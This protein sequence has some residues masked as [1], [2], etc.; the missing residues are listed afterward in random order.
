M[1]PLTLQFGGL[2]FGGGHTPTS[3]PGGSGS[4]NLPNVLGSLVS[5]QSSPSRGLGTIGGAA[6]AGAGGAGGQQ[7]PLPPSSM[8]GSVTAAA[9]AAA[10][11]AGSSSSPFAAMMAGAGQMAAATSV[12]AGKPVALDVTFQ[13]S[14]HVVM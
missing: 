13:D 7:P 2:N 9:A 5:G 10:A 4:F 6:V 8:D 14:D 12:T 1:H 3:A 11:A